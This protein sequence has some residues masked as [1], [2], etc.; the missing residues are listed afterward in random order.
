MCMHARVH[1]CTKR[2]KGGKGIERDPSK[3]KKKKKLKQK[4]HLNS[5]K[6][7]IV[8]DSKLLHLHQT[9]LFVRLALT[10]LK[11]GVPG[12]QMKAIMLS[13]YSSSFSE[14]IFLAILFF[15]STTLSLIQ[16]KSYK[17]S[18]LNSRPLVPSERSFSGQRD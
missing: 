8:K 7:Y 6:N 3:T 1:V 11:A 15:L 10:E 9:V 5:N 12:R 13:C 2:E 16:I 14:F 4:Q 18:S 17:R